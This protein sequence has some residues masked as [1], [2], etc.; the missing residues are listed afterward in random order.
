MKNLEQKEKEG[1][2]SEEEDDEEDVE[3]DMGGEPDEENQ[4]VVDEKL[5]DKDEDDDLKPQG[6]EKVE[7]D[8]PVQGEQEDVQLEAKQDDDDDER[9]K[10]KPKKD[11]KEEPPPPKKEGDEEA[12]KPRPEEAE[13]DQEGE[14]EGGDEDDKDDDKGDK[15]DKDDEGVKPETEFEENHHMDPKKEKPPEEEEEEGEAMPDEMPENMDL[16]GDD[17]DADEKEGDGDDGDD[18][19]GDVP[20]GMNVEPPPPDDK[21]GGNE[22][23]DEGDAEAPARGDEAPPDEDEELPEPMDHLPEGAQAMEDEGEEDG[24]KEDEGE[25]EGEGEEEDEERAAAAPFSAPKQYE[26]QQVFEDSQGQSNASLQPEAPPPQDVDDATAADRQ[27]SMPQDA[28]PQ[29]AQAQSLGDEGSEHVPSA[30][31][32]DAGAPPPPQ[33]RPPQQPNPYNSLGNALEHFHKQLQLME[34]EASKEA[35]DEEEDAAAKAAEEAEAKAAEEEALPPPGDEEESRQFE[36]A[37]KGE[38]ADAQVLADATQEQFEKEAD[39]EKPP[40]AGEEEDAP[41]PPQPPPK[42]DADGEADAGAEEATAAEE[43]PKRADEPKTKPN[44][45]GRLRPS[46][47][48]AAADD[49][50]EGEGEEAR[51]AE[52][53]KD[54][55]E[56]DDEG[57]EGD[58]A[59]PSL[60]G[61]P[62]AREAAGGAR[63]EEEEAA[64]RDD[65]D[66]AADAAMEAEEEAEAMR[67]GFEAE[68]A[69]WQLDGG[70][71]ATAEAV[72]RRF[73]QRT[74]GLA[75]EL[76]EQLRLILE[77]TVASK[78]QGD[79]RTGKRIS[80]RKVI[81]YIASGYRKDKIWLRRTKPSKRQYQVLL[82]IDDSES[83][84]HTGAGK[85]ACEALALLC[86]ALS[87]LEVGQMS[88]LSFAEQAQLLHPFE[89]PFSAEAG[90]HMLSR[91]TFAQKHTH[92]EALLQTVVQS[93]QLA[94]LQ[95]AAGSAE[96][97]QLCLIV[98]DGRRSPSWGDP[99][100]WI[101]RAAQ[102]HIMLCFVIVDAAAGEDSIMD[103]Q[104][105]SYPNGKLT[106][107]KWIDDF[108][109]PYYIVLR[110][111][112]TLP[113]VLSDA[114]RQWIELLQRT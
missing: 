15:D 19:E 40:G 89:R 102:Q 14:G 103:L 2:D 114:L 110:D 39:A 111:L 44:K 108:P 77:A 50:G 8:A 4:E 34:R 98:S 69:A 93:L 82:C 83:M 45:Q 35:D 31:R 12:E 74:N 96:Q 87:R 55:L 100:Q 65:D 43:E 11:E 28:A 36:I 3:Q 61:E 51:A 21:E 37:R 75:Q 97:M 81:P 7:K 80:M 24:D 86:Q 88:V 17:D 84:Q 54:F 109:F 92:M 56:E 107:S 6:D 5:W 104:T 33:R 91:F 16:D 64:A 67:E 62:S 72:W 113:Q 20:D 23:D 41:Q 101:R 60:M 90:A 48:A 22:D 29:A 32:P 73:E 26:E 57:A 106:I 105:V 78:L 52:P 9:P 112:A 18:A 46:T 85:L 13:G 79:Y 58:A 66:D 30:Q 25:G 49:E 68:L 71:G 94:R 1:S 38:A 27:A 99:T 70:G 42:E 76:C 47:E 59:R 63:P 53:Y 10:K 95:Q